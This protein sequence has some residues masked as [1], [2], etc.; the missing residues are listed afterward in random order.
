MVVR[1]EELH[2]SARADFGC[3]RRNGFMAKTV[4]W[5]ARDHFFA[6]QHDLLG[7]GAEQALPIGVPTSTSPPSR[8]ARRCRPRT[9]A[10]PST[11]TASARRAERSTFVRPRRFGSELIAVSTPQ[12]RPRGSCGSAASRRS[13]IKPAADAHRARTIRLEA[14]APHNPAPDVAPSLAAF[15]SNGSYRVAPT[16]GMVDGGGVG[17]VL[18]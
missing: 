1:R 15:S 4:I 10:S 12:W 14:A 9:P 13:I 16:L 11:A 6:V 7:Q 8:S 5:C 18:L 2:Q 17:A 3:A